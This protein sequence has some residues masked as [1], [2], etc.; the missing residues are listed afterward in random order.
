MDLGEKISKEEFC[1]DDV[2]STLDKWAGEPVEDMEAG[3]ERRFF[4]VN[5]CF[6]KFNLYEMKITYLRLL[7]TR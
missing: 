3:S 1:S 4:R 6:L 7:D 5:Q 2:K